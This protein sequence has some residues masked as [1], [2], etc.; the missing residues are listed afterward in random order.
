MQFN[1]SAESTKL[2]RWV[3]TVVPPAVGP[4][5]PEI[6]VLFWQV[7]HLPVPERA[8][9][10]TVH[11]DPADRDNLYKVAERVRAELKKANEPIDWVQKV[12]SHWCLTPLVARLTL[13]VSVL[14]GTLAIGADYAGLGEW[15]RELMW[16]SKGKE[17]LPTE[18][19]TPPMELL[20]SNLLPFDERSQVPEMG[21]QLLLVPKQPQPGRHAYLLTI[22]ALGATR[23]TPLIFP[24]TDTEI[25]HLP[26]SGTSTALVFTCARQ[27]TKSDAG[28]LKTELVKLGQAPPLD[29]SVNLVW[30]G[31]SITAAKGT[32]T[33]RAGFDKSEPGPQAGP[34]AWAASVRDILLIID[35]ATR[36]AGQSFPVLPK[37]STR[38]V[39][40]DLSLPRQD[41]PAALPVKDPAP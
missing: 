11:G 6:V 36:V 17:P 4:G 27:L 23:V 33:S 24:R 40:G 39:Q 26:A 7:P 8:R 13:I 2:R 9:V 29:L 15:A 12:K 20:T 30:S 19:P 14:T 21:D 38:A 5:E 34:L 18:P 31:L 10:L 37:G 22:D 25:I 1:G 16:G 32:S 28:Q 41:S 3:E 35:P